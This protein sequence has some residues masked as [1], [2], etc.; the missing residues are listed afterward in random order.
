MLHNFSIYREILVYYFHIHKFNEKHWLYGHIF[1]IYRC[2]VTPFLTTSFLT[3]IK[4]VSSLETRPTTVTRS[5]TLET[6]ASLYKVNYTE[7][8]MLLRG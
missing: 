2:S 5:T 6:S 4:L 7:R 8:L 1:V 3:K